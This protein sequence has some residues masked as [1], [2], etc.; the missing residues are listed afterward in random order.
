M[1]PVDRSYNAMVEIALDSSY[2]WT[3]LANF[4]ET[5]MKKKEI[6]GREHRVLEERQALFALDSS[7]TDD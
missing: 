1:G 7:D 4:C 3:A 2:Y 6:A 5:V